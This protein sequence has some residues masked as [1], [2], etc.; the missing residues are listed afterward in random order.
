[1]A[2]IE[3]GQKLIESRPF[4][5]LD[6]SPEHLASMMVAWSHREAG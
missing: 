3:S 2:L 1:M 5:G 6:H 4:A